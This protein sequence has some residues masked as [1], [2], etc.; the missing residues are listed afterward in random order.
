MICSANLFQRINLLIAILCVICFLIYAV[1]VFCAFLFVILCI[2]LNVSI[3]FTGIIFISEK[4]SAKKKIQ[5]ALMHSA[6]FCCFKDCTAPCHYFLQQ[7]SA[8][9]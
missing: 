1:C 6:Y 5:V 2:H 9:T 4:K 3:P 8:A 7:S